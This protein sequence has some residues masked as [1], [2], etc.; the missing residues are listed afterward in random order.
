[1]ELDLERPG[2]MSERLSNKSPLPRQSLGVI[3]AAFLG[4]IAPLALTGMIGGP[5]TLLTVSIVTAFIA[6]LVE[7]RSN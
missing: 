3:S 2:P 6:G 1:M 4:V 7:L 5:G